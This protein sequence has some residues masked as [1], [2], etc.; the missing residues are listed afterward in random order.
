MKKLEPKIL[1]LDIETS[2]NIAT[3]WTKW[4]PSMRVLK[5]KSIMCIAYKFLGDKNT[6]II[7]IT[8][9][10]TL[11][12]TDPF[13]DKEVIEKFIPI[14]EKADVIVAHNLDRFDA[15]LLNTRALKNKFI[16][17][18]VKQVDTLK[19]AKKYFSFYSNRLGDLAEYLGVKRKADNN[20]SW[21]D[22]V[23]L[24]KK[25]LSMKKIEKYCKTDVDVLEQVYNKLVVYHKPSIMKSLHSMSCPHCASLKVQK[26]GVYHTLKNSYQRFQCF[27]C[28]SWFKSNNK[29]MIV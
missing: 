8:E 10:E 20:I 5:D 27:S 19:I 12:K 7:S 25:R 28:F 26:R 16:L 22:D 17:P 24:H 2:Y 1:L 4:N 9:N 11:F 6:K 14:L 23:L 13:L 29:G 3:T 15:K 21:W 18:P